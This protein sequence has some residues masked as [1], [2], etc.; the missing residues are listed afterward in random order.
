MNKINIGRITPN[1]IW[2]LNKFSSISQ[3]PYDTLYPFSQ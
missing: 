1:K 2:S 3:N